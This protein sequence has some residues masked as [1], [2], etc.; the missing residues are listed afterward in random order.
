[1]LGGGHHRGGNA[2]PSARAQDDTRHRRRQRRRRRATTSSRIVSSRKRRPAQRGCPASNVATGAANVL[3]APGGRRQEQ[4]SGVPGWKSW[5]HVCSVHGSLRPPPS[6]PDRP[7]V[8]RGVPA[9]TVGEVH[10]DPR[11]APRG[12]GPG[13]SPWSDDYAAEASTA[14]SGR[15]TEQQPAPWP[16]SA[17]PARVAE[18]R[19]AVSRSPRRLPPR[20]VTLPAVAVVPPEAWTN[21]RPYAP[22]HRKGT[23]R[24]RQADREEENEQTGK[25]NRF[26]LVSMTARLPKAEESGTASRSRWHRPW[27]RGARRR[28]AAA[29]RT[30]GGEQRDHGEHPVDRQPPAQERRQGSKKPRPPTKPGTPIR[31]DDR[32]HDD[33]AD[34]GPPP[35]HA[36]TGFAGDRGRRRLPVARGSSRRSSPASEPAESLR[37]LPRP[38]GR[39][40]SSPRRIPP[41]AADKVGGVDPG[42]RHAGDV[43]V[44]DIIAEGH[45]R[46]VTAGHDLDVLEGSRLHRV[47]WMKAAAG[48]P[49][50]SA[51]CELATAGVPARTARMPPHARYAMTWGGSKCGSV[52]T[53]QAVDQAPELRADAVVSVETVDEARTR[54]SQVSSIGLLL[55]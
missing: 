23:K 24:H 14:P 7:P 50:S 10:P 6:R 34:P 46:P 18:A 52:A 25:T 35:H 22:E 4:G 43:N 2:G 11:P 37:S 48:E 36:L 45:R 31:P 54:S 16:A 1:M 29:I 38:D 15:G 40:S 5:P 13:A 47:V 3:D 39:V 55:R 19:L 12:S 44:G 21:L 53:I 17:D 49:R 8:S 20:R 30:T 28:I 33:G 32:G 27:R 42:R 26:G 41:A 51:E 9:I